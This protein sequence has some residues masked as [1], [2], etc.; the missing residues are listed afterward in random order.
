M[1]LAKL[2]LACPQALAEQMVEF[3]LESP[4]LRDGFTTLAGSGHG[5]DFATASLRERVRGRI[6]V[7]L[8]M[9]ILPAGD[10]PALLAQLRAQFRAP[11]I[12]Y[13]TEP[14]QS[15]GDLT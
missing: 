4:S 3:L 9:T 10:I 14:V 5:A 15:L 8:V 12:R 6:Q 7:T 11:H 2:T 1:T 13:W